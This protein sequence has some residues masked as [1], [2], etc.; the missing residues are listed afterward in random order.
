MKIST[1]PDGN[2]RL[3]LNLAES[4]VLEQL[5]H[6]LQDVLAPDALRADDAV[7]QRLY[8]A[9]YED[10]A[11]AQAY[12]E[13]TE[14]ALQADRSSRVDECRAELRSGRSIRR[15]EVVLDADTA[16]RWLQVLNDMR[17]AF[18]TRLQISE[19]DE[20]ELNEADPD[21]QLRARYLWLTALQD[22]LVTTLMG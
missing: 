17:L 19:D 14:S 6:E 8:P 4:H 2:A 18:G 7:R 16:E 20:Y 11:Q 12:R 3:R 21:V 15:T 22:A 1:A 9:A 13:L 10:A 5:F